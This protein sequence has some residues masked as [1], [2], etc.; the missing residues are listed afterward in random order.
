MIDAK[1]KKRY[2]RKHHERSYALSLVIKRK[3]LENILSIWKKAG[4]NWLIKNRYIGINNSK[5]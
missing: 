2:R 3:M 1:Y 4:S 5:Y